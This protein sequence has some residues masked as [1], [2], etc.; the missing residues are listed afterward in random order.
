M[1]KL[2]Q[3]TALSLLLA[4]GGL[5]SAE[6]IVIYH[7][8]DTHGQFY[9]KMDLQNKARGKRGGFAALSAL[10]RKEKY[11][12]ILLD[13]GD[14]AQGSEETNVTQGMASVELMNKLGYSAATAGNH[15]FDF[16]ADNLKKLSKEANFPILGANVFLQRTHK[17]PSYLK[18][19]TI[20]KAGKRKIA[21]IGFATVETADS[22]IPDSVAPFY[23]RD[24]ITMV[25]DILKQAD[26]HKP[27]AYVFLMHSG[28]AKNLNS[29]T[30][31]HGEKLFTKNNNSVNLML[32]RFIKRPYSIILGGHEH[33]G[34]VGAVD[35]VSG[36]FFAESYAYLNSV[37]R[38]ELDFDDDTDKLISIN[39]HLIDLYIDEIGEDT[40][41]L[42]LSDKFKNKDHTIIHGTASSDIL[43]TSQTSADNP[44]ANLLTDAMREATG[45]QIAILNGGAVRADVEAGPVSEK[46]VLS[47]FPFKDPLVT[48]KIS[49][50][51]LEQLI[52]QNI[53]ADNHA[54]IGMSNI[55]VEFNG[56]T[57]EIISLKIDGQPVH[58][59]ELYTI[60]ANSYMALGY[61][62]G[63][64][65]KQTGT[66]IETR[67][68]VQSAFRDYVIK[69]KELPA[70]E[71]TRIG[72]QQGTLI[73][74]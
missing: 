7:T 19:Y 18:P 33:T 21:V 37:T 59:R 26:K 2:Y 16:G 22:S 4:L 66:K 14:F 36:S 64:V 39:S 35:P 71:E 52:K 43:R 60:T 9:S 56:K 41:V 29:K 51:Q 20:L 63:D 32:A 31:I 61:E 50:A 45:T 72:L 6:T 25:K 67:F 30:D 24:P 34:I 27:D 40:N 53:D 10:I 58:P 12:Y 44:L 13:S 48:F 55:T 47:V 11:P 46:T 74:L 1:I 28:L 3:I 69:H 15:E 68:T 54:K 17:R 70:Q 57:K 65:F 49:G 73:K 42:V 8:S 38:L 5:L 62:G 23:F